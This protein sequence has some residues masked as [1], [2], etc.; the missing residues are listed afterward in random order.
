MKETTAQQ[1][2][3]LRCGRRI[4]AASSVKAAYGPGCRARIRAAALAKALAG[5]TAAQVEKARELI[6]DGGLIATKRPGV[7]R[8]VSSKGDATYLSHSAT[9]NCPAGLRSRTACYHVAAVRMI[10]GRAA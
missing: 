3:C 9:C 2:H 6:A 1:A 4:W 8:A 7:Y 5:F 10:T